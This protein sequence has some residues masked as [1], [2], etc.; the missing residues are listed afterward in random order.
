MLETVI[1]YLWTLEPVSKP[2]GRQST[3][4]VRARIQG[5][6]EELPQKWASKSTGLRKHLKLQKLVKTTQQFCSA[7]AHT[8]MQHSKSQSV[9]K[10]AACSY[11]HRFSRTGKEI[12]TR[13]PVRWRSLHMTAGNQ[14]CH[15]KFPSAECLSSSPL[16]CRPQVWVC[17]S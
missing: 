9:R 16:I 2:Q 3:C 1:V 8:H 13:C 6:T 11:L 12:S 15:P 10:A 5:K 17:R 14:I 4:I 7:K